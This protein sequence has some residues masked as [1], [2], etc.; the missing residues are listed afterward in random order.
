MHQALDDD[1]STEN[2]IIVRKNRCFQS[3]TAVFMVRVGRFELPASWTQIKR[4]TNW[5]TPGYLTIQLDRLEIFIPI[6]V[7]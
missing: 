2:A 7:K 1:G 4:P 6:V 3:K 5:A